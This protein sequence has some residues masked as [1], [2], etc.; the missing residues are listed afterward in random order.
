[1]KSTFPNRAKGSPFCLQDDE[2][3]TAFKIEHWSLLRV[4]LLWGFD[5]PLIKSAQ[6]YRYFPHPTAAWLVRKGTL[7]LRFPSGEETYCAGQWVFPKQMPGRQIFSEDTELLSLRFYAEWQNGR[8]LFSRDQ[9]IVIPEAEAPLLGQAAESLIRFIDGRLLPPDHKGIML[10]G[11]LGDYL[12]LQPLMAQWIDVWY[13][14]FLKHGYRPELVGP[15]EDVVRR[16]IAYLQNRP[17]NTPFYEKE[18]ADHVGLSISQ[19]NRLFTRQVKLTPKDFWNYKRLEFAQSA[20]LGS[21]ESIK[22]I[23]FSLGFL[24]PESFT[25]WFHKNTSYSPKIY[26][27][28]LD[29]RSDG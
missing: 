10:K 29:W 21:R 23:S 7:T 5:N 20:L 2:H 3:H 27:A 25:R 22:G 26:R 6:D 19:I 18:L 8:P 13:R 9:T 28:T 14:T 4:Q 16:C 15:F 11:N 12:A 24:T 17:L 1:M